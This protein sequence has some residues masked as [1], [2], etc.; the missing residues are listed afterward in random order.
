MNKN[1][2]AHLLHDYKDKGLFKVKLGKTKRNPN[3]RT[4]EYRHHDNSQ[5]LASWYTNEIPLNKS[6]KISFQLADK[7]GQ[8]VE[9]EREVFIFCDAGYHKFF[10]EMNCLFELTYDSKKQQKI[11]LYPEYNA[12]VTLERK[13]KFLDVFKDESI[14]TEDKIKQK[15]GFGWRKYKAVRDYL[16]EQKLIIPNSNHSFSLT[17]NSPVLDSWLGG[18]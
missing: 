5:L 8:K 18:K 11:K 14:I 1:L 9:G 10:K 15:T 4:N 7:Y 3:K 13:D 2:Y 6:E 17:K 12:W 16:L